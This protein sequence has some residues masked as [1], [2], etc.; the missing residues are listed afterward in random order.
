MVE[1][2]KVLLDKVDNLDNVANSLTKPVSIDKLSWCREAM[3]ISS[4]D[5]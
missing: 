3:G 5:F 2:K 1:S 4:L